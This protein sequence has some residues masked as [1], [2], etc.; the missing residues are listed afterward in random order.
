MI[1]AMSRKE[2]RR[3]WSG[4]RGKRCLPKE[5][6]RL[7]RRDAMLKKRRLTSS[8]PAQSCNISSSNAQGVSSHRQRLWEE[9]CSLDS[10]SCACC[11]PNFVDSPAVNLSFSRCA[12]CIDFQRANCAC[13]PVAA[14]GKSDAGK[15][16]RVISVLLETGSAPR[17]SVT[18]KEP[19]RHG[20]PC[21]PSFNL[22]FRT[23]QPSTPRLSSSGKYIASHIEGARVGKLFPAAIYQIISFPEAVGG[24]YGDSETP[25]ASQAACVEGA[26]YPRER[27]Q[28]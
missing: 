27:L 22:Q 15:P 23:F 24:D 19:K 12:C 2:D 5:A 9:H 10:V 16:I 25:S 17:F 1:R 4:K 14:G 7:A 11:D 20:Q 26:K 8:S 21:L 28:P 6:R 18:L 13:W 3:R